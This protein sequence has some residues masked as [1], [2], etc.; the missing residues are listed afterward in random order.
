[1]GAQVS[2]A[3]QA[4]LRPMLP[5][6]VP[7]LAAIFQASVDE[8][9]EEDYD[10]AQRNV[11]AAQADDEA[12]FGARLGQA[13]TVVATIEGA[14]VGFVSLA[15]KTRIDML[16]VYPRMARQGVGSLLYDAIEKLAASRGA[17][18][19]EVDA[20]DTA[21]PFFEQKGF[22]PLHRQTVALGD[23]WLGNTRMEKQL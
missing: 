10:D 1:M 18:R 5:A 14:P 4:A 11:W 22:T 13:L 12:A 2:A 8:L 15:G 7:V 20:S 6:D 3:P 19:L 21:R 17:N 9:T 16:Y 23:C